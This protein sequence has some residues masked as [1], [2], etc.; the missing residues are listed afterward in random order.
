MSVVGVTAV[1]QRKS[2]LDSGY[3]INVGYNPAEGRCF[4]PEKKGRYLFILFIAPS[5]P[6]EL[7][8]FGQIIRLRERTG[9]QVGVQV[10]PDPN[11]PLRFSHMNRLRRRARHRRGF[12]DRDLG[13]PIDVTR[14]SLRPK[15]HVVAVPGVSPV[16]RP[17]LS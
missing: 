2:V 7:P 3:W 6:M 5:L 15:V 12:V 1:V 8:V 17:P 13:G 16:R 10:S 4:S 14:L 9:C 11:S